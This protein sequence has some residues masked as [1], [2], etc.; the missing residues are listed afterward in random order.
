MKQIN[1]IKQLKTA[2]VTCMLLFAIVI[3]TGCNDSSTNSSTEVTDS[4]ANRMS[5]TS[6][7]MS[8]DTTPKFDSLQ[9]RTDTSRSDQTPPPPR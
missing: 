5:D 4:T 9:N 3:F 6:A 7:V 8:T 1:F 2:I